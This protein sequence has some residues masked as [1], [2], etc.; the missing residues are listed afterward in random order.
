MI[1]TRLSVKKYLN[2]ISAH[3]KPFV[4]ILLLIAR[5]PSFKDRHSHSGKHKNRS[6]KNHYK[7][8]KPDLFII[9]FSRFSAVF[10]HF[11]SGTKNKVLYPVNTTYSVH[12]EYSVYHR[13]LL[14]I[15]IARHYDF[16][17][18]GSF[19]NIGQWIF[20]LSEQP[21]TLHVYVT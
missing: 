5:K 4:K 11:S 13:A 17:N 18:Q 10:R 19:H 20:S 1:L 14:Q 12:S 6:C 3:F 15:N 16:F 7:L 9:S 21:F 2:F 8:C